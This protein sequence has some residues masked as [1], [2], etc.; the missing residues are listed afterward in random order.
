MM[1]RKRVA[2]AAVPAAIIGGML[3]PWSSPTSAATGCRSCTYEK[4]AKCD[5]DASGGFFSR[6]TNKTQF[7][8][9]RG[10]GACKQD[11]H[12]RHDQ[13]RDNQARRFR[14]SD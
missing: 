3:V 9:S 13:R 12:D 10:T 2:L 5:V 7:R 6:V 8:V 11:D 14:S 1:L 4:T